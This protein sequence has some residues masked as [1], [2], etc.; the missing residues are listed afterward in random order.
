VNFIRFRA[1]FCK[2]RVFILCP[3]LTG[4]RYAGIYLEKIVF[5]SKQDGRE[6]AAIEFSE[7]REQTDANGVPALPMMRLTMVIRTERGH[8]P[9]VVHAAL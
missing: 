2:V 3:S 6:S 5:L 8:I 4:V 7:H 9:L 1:I